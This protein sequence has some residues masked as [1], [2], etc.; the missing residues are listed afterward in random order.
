M[1]L[2]CGLCHTS[3]S[4]LVCEQVAVWR[5]HL[6]ALC[7]LRRAVRPVQSDQPDSSL[8][9]VLPQ[10]LL[11]K[12]RWGVQKKP[13]WEGNRTWTPRWLQE[14]G[15][16]DFKSVKFH[17]LS[18]QVASSLRL[19]P[20]SWWWEC[21]VMPLCLPWG[22][23][24]SGAVTVQNLTALPAALTGGRQ[25]T[26]CRLCLTSFAFS[27]FAT[28]CPAP[29]SS[30]PTR[31][32]WWRCGGHAKPSSSTCHHRQRPPTPMLSLSRWAC[33]FWTLREAFYHF[34]HLSHVCRYITDWP[35]STGMVKEPIMTGVSLLF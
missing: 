1:N 33:A 24:C 7:H 31:A 9:G 35:N 15:K 19:T 18:Y 5:A 11:P 16:A 34:L 20:V 2:P 21:G 25:T 27:S 17:F 26:S 14:G 28:C 30:S 32:S 6:S 13:H 29:S 22:P 3:S 8:F 4:L 10:S 12:P 23:C